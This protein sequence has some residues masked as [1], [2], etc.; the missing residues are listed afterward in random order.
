MKRVTL[1]GTGYITE[2]A[3]VPAWQKLRSKVEIAAICDLNLG[4]AQALAARLGVSESYD[5]LGAMLSEVR[6]DLVDVCT[7]PG[8]HADLVV[9]S[10]M[11][12]A[13]VVVEKPLALTA[14][15]CRRIIEVEKTSEKSV[16]V[17]HSEL[18]YMPVIEAR[19]RVAAGEIGDVTGMRMFRATPV[20]TMIADPDHWAPRL[21]GGAIGETGPHVVYTAREFIGPIVDVVAHGRKMLSEYPWSPYEDYRIE[22]V[23]EKAT[24]SAVVTYTNEHSAAHID[25]WGTEGMLRLELQ[26]RVLVSYRRQG[27][28]PLAIGASALREAAAMAAGVAGTAAKFLAGAHESPHDIFIREFFDAVTDDRPLP[29]TSADGL[30]NVEV[31][32]GIAGQLRKQASECHAVEE[33]RR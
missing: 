17:V 2:K 13:D 26:S 29:V 22:L 27:M 28:G 18:F 6:P 12:G 9:E 20:A 32:E 4:R 24:A 21:P 19:K 23:G 30:V 25:I 10:L 11:A 3:H 8:T 31:M 5:D 14:E 7:P 33:A 16:G 1:V 15:D